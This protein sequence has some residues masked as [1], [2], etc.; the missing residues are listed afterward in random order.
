[1]AIFRRPGRG[2]IEIVASPSLSPCASGIPVG[3]RGFWVQ[4]FVG[5][6][7]MIA[8]D[9]YLLLRGCEASWLSGA[10]LPPFLDHAFT[11]HPVPLSCSPADTL[12]EE[13]AASVYRAAVTKALRAIRQGDFEKVVLSRLKKML[14][15]KDFSYGACLAR[16]NAYYTNTF[17]YVL[18]APDR[19]LWLGASPESLLR[20]QDNRLYTQALAATKRLAAGSLP[21]GAGAVSWAEKERAEQQYVVQHL[22]STLREAGIAHTLSPPRTHL[23][24]GMAHLSSGC[25]AD[26]PDASFPKIHELLRAL[27]PTPAVC[28]FPSSL[29]KSFILRYETHERSHYTGY[30]GPVGIQSDLDLYVNIRC[31]ACQQGHAHLYAGAGIVAGSSPHAEWAE[32]TLKMATMERVLSSA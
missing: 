4:P 30:L 14:L 9:F 31:V 24:N 18:Y 23:L 3:T 27:H 21:T 25:L 12:G 26:F 8:A 1:M 11:S 28:G 29:A 16:M 7:G 2:E 10:P 20:I 5:A 22:V 13:T 15:P 32:T 19:A 17:N 6:G